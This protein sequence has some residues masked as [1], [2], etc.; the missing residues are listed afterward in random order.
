[1]KKTIE[2]ID[3]SLPVSNVAGRIWGGKTARD[4]KVKAFLTGLAESSDDEAA[5]PD[6]SA[7]VLLTM[8]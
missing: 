8:L 6:V 4:I 5:A 7:I 2:I 1:M 3:K